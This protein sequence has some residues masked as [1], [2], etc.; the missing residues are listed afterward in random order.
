MF[1]RVTDES[2]VD[3]EWL[4][5]SGIPTDVLIAEAGRA[6]LV[7]LSGNPG[8]DPEGAL[9]KIPPADVIMSC[10]TPVIVL[11]PQPPAGFKA[12]RIL[13]A[14]KNTAQAA[15]AVRDA[16]P[17]LQLAERVILTE[18][19]EDAPPWRYGI[20]AD[21]M[22]EYLETH[23]VAVSI[24]R[25]PAAG[26]PGEQLIEAAYDNHC[27]LIVAGAYGHSRIREWALGGVTRSLLGASTLPC[28]FS[29]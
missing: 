14:W 13:L 27:D 4:E 16:L 22:A 10:G 2:P 23:N 5:A 29:H 15:R 1:D 18:I 19:V 24:H 7:I 11:P 12:R 6:D 3:A 25:L 28:I 20:L 26:D 21:S 17:V 9:Y 8:A